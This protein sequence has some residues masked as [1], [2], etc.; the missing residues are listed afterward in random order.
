MVSYTLKSPT[1]NG[2]LEDLV[3]GLVRCLDLLSLGSNS[4]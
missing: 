2:P 3:L 1:V 4:W